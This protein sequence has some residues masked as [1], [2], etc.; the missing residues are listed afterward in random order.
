[1]KPK[2]IDALKSLS[3]LALSGPNL[4]PLVVY[5]S[6]ASIA[7]KLAEDVNDPECL[8]LASTAKRAMITARAVRDADLCEIEFRDFLHMEGEAV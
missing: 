5:D 4:E 2:P 3:E 6:V 7:A 1:M 8:N